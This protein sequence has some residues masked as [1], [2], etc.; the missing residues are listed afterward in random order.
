VARDLGAAFVGPG[1]GDEDPGRR[2]LACA[3]RPEEPED[4]TLAHAERDAVE[5]LH[6]AIPLPKPLDD[7]RVHRQRV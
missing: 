7:D 2:R 3:V 6:G 5:R 1:E 4:L